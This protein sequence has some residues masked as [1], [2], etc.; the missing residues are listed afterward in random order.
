MYKSGYAKS[1]ITAPVSMIREI[2]NAERLGIFRLAI[3]IMYHK[4]NITSRAFIYR[5]KCSLIFFLQQGKNNPHIYV[6]S[7]FVLYHFI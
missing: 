7:I 5:K 2:T 3:L 4:Q 1:Q 6:V